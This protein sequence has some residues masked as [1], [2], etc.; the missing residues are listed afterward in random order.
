LF[1]DFHGRSV[2]LMELNGLLGYYCGRTRS[3]SALITSG[4]LEYLLTA[5]QRILLRSFALAI[6]FAL[7]VAAVGWLGD[8]LNVGPGQVPIWDPEGRGYWIAAL[9]LVL[10]TAMNY[11]L[12]DSPPEDSST[13]IRSDNNDRSIGEYETNWILPTLVVL[14]GVT[15][16]GVYRGTEAIVI[17]A[18]LTFLGLTAGPISR[19][20]IMLSEQAVRERARVVFTMIVHGAAFLTMAMIYIHKMRSLF[21]A[22]AVLIVGFLLFLALTEGEDGVFI[23]RLV[24]ALVGGVMLGQVTWALNYWQATGWTGGAVLLV[25]FYLFGGIVL[26]HLR[27]GVQ[28]RDVLEYG[29]VSLIAIGIVVYSLFI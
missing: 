1:P 29:A 19:H 11:R 2:Q 15:L 18:G 13:I 10:V 28:A 22:P 26:T 3:A 24:Y 4:T 27:Q 8:E 23:R 12:L 17:G 7:L 5:N 20:A 6:V 25:C 16:L 21:S 14:T 9:L